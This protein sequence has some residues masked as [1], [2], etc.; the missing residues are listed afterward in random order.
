M[1]PITLQLRMS[2]FWAWIRLSPF[3]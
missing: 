2:W 1:M 3:S